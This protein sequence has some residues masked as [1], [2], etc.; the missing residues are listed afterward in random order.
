MR[1]IT[2]I[3]ALAMAAI[4]AQS[5]QTSF[6]ISEGF[7]PGELVD[8]INRWQET[9]DTSNYFFV[10]SENASEGENSLKMTY[11]SS[12]PLIFADWNFAEALPVQDDL[13][14]TIHLYPLKNI[15]IHARIGKQLFKGPVDL[16]AFERCLTGTRHKLYYNGDITNVAAYKAIKERFPTLDHF[17]IGRG[18][19]ADPFLPS[20][21]KN[22]TT[23]Y[24]ENRWAIFSEFHYTIYKQ[25][26]EYLSGPTP[27]K[28]K[29]LGFWEYF[30]Q[31]T[32]NPQKT[33]KAI[34][35]ASNPV[36]YRQA[37]AQIINNEMKIAKG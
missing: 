15:A 16:D 31:S 37:V 29:M 19:I 14:I 7:T 2:L 11:D 36:K 12:Q 6:E 8:G 24:P 9:S 21:I 13:E 35:K 4:S 25:Y 34:K 18:L 23:E 20:M 30:S 5:Q 32:S 33:Y 17:M 22:N 28:M 26:D 1:K 27:I 10:S 3:L